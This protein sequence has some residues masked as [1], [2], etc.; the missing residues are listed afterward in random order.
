LLPFKQGVRC[1]AVKV[2]PS[3]LIRPD[4]CVAWTDDGND[5]SGLKATLDRW[6][7]PA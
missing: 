5:I 1:V 4:A 3:Q 7:V 6:F 2:G